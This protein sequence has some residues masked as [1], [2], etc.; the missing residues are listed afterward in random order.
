M[1]EEAVNIAL[2]LLADI[3]VNTKRIATL[4]EENDGE[5]EED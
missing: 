3:A 4:L 2:G 5:E 1:D